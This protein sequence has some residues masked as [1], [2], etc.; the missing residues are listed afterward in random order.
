MKINIDGEYELEDNITQAILEDFCKLIKKYEDIVYK[1]RPFIGEAY[2]A[3]GF[4]REAMEEA[5]FENE[6]F[7][8]YQEK[9]N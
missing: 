8:D 7:V 3:L 6:I 5:L 1:D 9:Y 2:L 4:L